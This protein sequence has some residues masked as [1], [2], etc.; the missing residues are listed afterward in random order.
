MDAKAAR[1]RARWAVGVSIVAVW[2]GEAYRTDCGNE[3]EGGGSEWDVFMD[4]RW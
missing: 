3:T 1:K 2:V 4:T